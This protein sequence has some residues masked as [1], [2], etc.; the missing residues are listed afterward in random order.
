FFLYQNGLAGVALR[1]STI[2]DIYL[3]VKICNLRVCCIL[4]DETATLFHIMRQFFFR[5]SVMVISIFIVHSTDIV[6]RMENFVPDDGA[7]SAQICD[8]YM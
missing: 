3:N 2:Y 8:P 4:I 1:G 7:Q 6:Q 5:P